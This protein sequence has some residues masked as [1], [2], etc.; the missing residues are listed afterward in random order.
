MKTFCVHS[1]FQSWK[2]GDY[3]VSPYV[4]I[5]LGDHVTADGERLLTPQLMTDSEID[6]E[7]NRKI[8]EL[9]LVRKQAKR[10]LSARQK[11]MLSSASD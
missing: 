3:P 2:K 8:E 1:P 11:A 5:A 7:I 10:E 9:Q 4:A 6:Y